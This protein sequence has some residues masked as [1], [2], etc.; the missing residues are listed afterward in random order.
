MF[1]IIQIST[2][3]C[4]QNRYPSLNSNITEAKRIASWFRWFYDQFMSS[5][6]F[7]REKRITAIFLPLFYGKSRWNCLRRYL[8]TV[9]K[10]IL[11]IAPNDSTV[12]LFFVMNRI[13]LYIVN[14][15]IACFSR[16]Q[17][18]SKIRAPCKSSKR[19][20]SDLRNEPKFRSSSILR[21][22]LK[23]LSNVTWKII[24]NLK[25]V[26]WHWSDCKG[27]WSRCWYFGTWK[28]PHLWPSRHWRPGSRPVQG[29]RYSRLQCIHGRV[30][31]SHHYRDNHVNTICT[32]FQIFTLPTSAIVELLT[33]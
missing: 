15:E 4:L 31:Q 3:H 17:R 19:K 14:N 22:T 5:K 8:T 23:R 9:S 11:L 16:E 27:S 32:K 1:I 2:C 12:G 25:L 6:I 24:D 10:L 26:I 13:N 18:F 33:V 20:K 7:F 30:H 28:I 29:C 21:P